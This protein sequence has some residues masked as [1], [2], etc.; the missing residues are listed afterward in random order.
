MAEGFLI[1]VDLDAVKATDLDTELAVKPPSTQEGLGLKTISFLG[2]V[3]IQVNSEN[4][5]SAI[6][7]IRKH[8][9]CIATYCDV[10]ALTNITEVISLL[11]N[12]ASKVFVTQSQLK[13]IVEQ[14]VLEDLGRLVVSLDKPDRNSHPAPAA[15]K[16]K[17]DVRTLVR[18]V[19]V[20]L[21]VDDVDEWKWLDT[22]QKDAQSNQ[23]HFSRYVK[24]RSYT[25]QSYVR[26]VQ[27]G[28]IPIVP[29]NTL[30][31]DSDTF[32]QLIAAHC[33]ITAVVVS[34]RSDGLFPTVVCDEHG[35]CL[36]LVYSDEKS[37]EC[38]L[39]LGRGVYHSRSRNRL[40]IKGEESGDIQELIRIVWDCD[41]DSLRF[42]VRQ[43]G[44][45][46]PNL[47]VGLD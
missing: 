37:I 39:R 45:G 25:L 6:S 11:D 36:G 46:K 40:W 29:A 34:D 1:S 12:G 35:S 43:R 24:L 47:L 28:D 2:R 20:A 33:L 4:C 8:F 42:T 31:I 10:T 26:T 5:H 23:G 14:G 21:Q 19:P 3:H 30:T 41:A 27:A 32:P 18:S 44:N 7:F 15:E 22:I 13:Q 9:T 16:F 38:A 17:A